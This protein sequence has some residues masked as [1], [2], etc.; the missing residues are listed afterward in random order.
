MQIG[1][2]GRIHD[3]SGGQP[4]MV[5]VPSMMPCLKTACTK[6]SKEYGNCIERVIDDFKLAALKASLPPGS[7]PTI[8]KLGDAP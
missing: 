4:V 3:P 1:K 5:P 2:G 6:W 8:A 7:H